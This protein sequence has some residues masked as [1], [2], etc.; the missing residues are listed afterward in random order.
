MFSLAH[1]I[2]IR[3]SISTS[4]VNVGGKHDLCICL[5]LPQPFRIRI[6]FSMGTPPLSQLTLSLSLGSL[7]SNDDM[8]RPKKIAT[9]SKW[10]RLRGLPYMMSAKFSDFFT[11]SPLSTNSRNISD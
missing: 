10:P 7:V 4:C 11:P 6:L 5:S 8:G 1:F 9:F 2:Y 3:W